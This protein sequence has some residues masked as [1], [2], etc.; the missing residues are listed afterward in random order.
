MCEDYEYR[1][2]SSLESQVTEGIHS[3]DCKSLAGLMEWSV[4]GHSHVHTGD[5]LQYGSNQGLSVGSPKW[6]AIHVPGS[7]PTHRAIKGVFVLDLW[8]TVIL[9]LNKLGL[10]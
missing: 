7:K 3:K 5:S 4:A 6:T 8:K 2:R 1:A 9:N 10:I